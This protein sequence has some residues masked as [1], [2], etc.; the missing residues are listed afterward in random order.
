MTPVSFCRL[1]F[2]KV[3]SPATSRDFL[4]SPIYY[5]TFLGS[6]AV[7]NGWVAKYPGA[8]GAETW[9]EKKNVQE[10]HN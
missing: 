4:L 6:E 7:G 2:V 3:Q 9:V 1:P 8:N 5:Y 10:K